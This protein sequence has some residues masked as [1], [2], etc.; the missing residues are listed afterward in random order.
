[1]AWSTPQTWVDGVVITAAADMNPHVRDNLR[2]LK[3]LD[4]VPYIENALE[5][6]ELA[7]PATPASGRARLWP[8]TSGLLY[9]IDDAAN[10][11][12]LGQFRARVYNNAAISIATGTNTALTFNTQRTNVGG[13]HSTGTNPGRLTAPVA[14]AYLLGAHVSFASNTTG[15]RYAQL[16]INGTTYVAITAMLALTGGNATIISV[17]ALYQ[18][19]AGDYAEVVAFQSSGGNLDVAASGNYS[20]EFWMLGPF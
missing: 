17:C 2:Y 10:T 18:M 19:A 3:G 14:G 8:A 4:G 13:L 6:P 16:R 1:M 20:P 9:G 15:V 7:T 12:A 5:L 11:Y